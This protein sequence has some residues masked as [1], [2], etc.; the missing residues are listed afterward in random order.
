ME[1]NKA[2]GNFAHIIMNDS[3]H[4]QNNADLG[5]KNVMGLGDFKSWQFFFNWKRGRG[6]VSNNGGGNFTSSGALL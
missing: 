2:E 5:E 1:Y 3:R 4:R 6:G